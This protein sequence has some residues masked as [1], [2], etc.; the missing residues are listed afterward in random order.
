MSFLDGLT[1]MPRREVAV[2]NPVA[3]AVEK[4]VDQVRESNPEAILKVKGRARFKVVGPDEAGVLVT[5]Q[6]TPW[7]DN[8]LTTYGLAS[9]ASAIGSSAAVT[10]S[11][12]IQAIYIGTSTT[13]PTSTDTILGAST[14]SLTI[15]NASF[16]KTN[17]GNMTV[18]YQASWASNNPAGSCII[19]EIGIYCNSTGTEVQNKLAAHATLA[20]QVSKGASDS[21]YSSYDV[22]WTTS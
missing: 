10:A 11:N 15:G 4:W 14:A 8:I 19:G 9:M 20:T 5:K 13:A 6:E 22:V 2:T 16:T 17:L 21:T 18:E 12:W 7:F 3:R 1:R